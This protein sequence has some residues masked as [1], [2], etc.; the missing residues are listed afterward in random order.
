MPTIIVWFRGQWECFSNFYPA[1]VSLDGALYP[2]VE[3]AYQAAKTLNP[4]ERSSFADCSPTV[5]K[6]LGRR[7]RLRP[8]WEEVKLSVMR[9]L[10]LQKF[11]RGTPCG[12]TLL[13]SGSAYLWEGNTWHD[14]YWGVCV[15][16]RCASKQHLNRLGEL[17]MRIREDLCVGNKN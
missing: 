9:D 2:T 3:N 6:R 15:C 5:A 11:A 7:V 13:R 4:E 12:E 1:P 14:N 17:L 16:G 8:D 10:L